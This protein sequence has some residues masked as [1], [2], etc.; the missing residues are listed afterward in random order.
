MQRRFEPQKP[1]S[2]T[3]T[4]RFFLSAQ[5]QVDVPWRNWGSKWSAYR[6]RVIF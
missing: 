1:V 5:V 4:G 2:M 6:A 3:D